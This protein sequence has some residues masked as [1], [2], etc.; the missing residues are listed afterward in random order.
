MAKT[1]NCAFCGK[2]ITKGFFTGDD[3]TVD[4]GGGSIT[5][6]EDCYKLYHAD[7][8]KHRTRFGTKIENWKKASKRKPSQKELADMYVRYLKEEAEQ[9]AKCGIQIMNATLGCFVLGDNG[10]F[11]VREKRIG[12]NSISAKEMIKTLDKA[13]DLESFYFDKDDIT[14]L[15]FKRTGIGDPLTLFSTAFSYEIRLNDEKVLTYKP[16][17]AEMAVIGSGIGLYIFKRKSADKKMYKFLEDFR[18]VIG[19]DLPITKVKK[20]T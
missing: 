8:K 3:R 1:T 15:E 9:S 4:T 2:E 12:S 14:K 13:V 18:Q 6:C 5:C 19:S 11:A 20:F 16:C 17:M 10:C 7:E